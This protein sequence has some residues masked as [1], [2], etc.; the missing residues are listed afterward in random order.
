M[1]KFNWP[2]PILVA[3]ATGWPI[4]LNTVKADPESCKS[5]LLTKFT[6]QTEMNHRS[7]CHNLI[8]ISWYQIS[9][10]YLWYIYFTWPT[11]LEFMTGV[12]TKTGWLSWQ[13]PYDH[14]RYWRLLY[15]QSLWN[16]TGVSAALLLRRLSNFRAIIAF[17]TSHDDGVV[18]ILPFHFDE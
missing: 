18:S 12:N 8:K 17:T 9:A 6:V 7:C 3:R 10:C 14:L 4:V 13:Q 11:S 5:C 15:W 16:L 1:W 2:S